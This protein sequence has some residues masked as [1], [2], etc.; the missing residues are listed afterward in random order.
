MSEN[1]RGADGLWRFPNGDLHP[2][3]LTY[4]YDPDGRLRE[5]SLPRDNYK[6]ADEL[7]HYPDGLLHPR[8]LYVTDGPTIYDD[9]DNDSSAE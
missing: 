1:Y 7:C 6:G 8:N 4:I 9:T 5:T 3:N 2:R